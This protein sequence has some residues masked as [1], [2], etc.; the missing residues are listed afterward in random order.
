MYKDDV[1][2]ETLSVVVSDSK[3]TLNVML[4]A[5]KLAMRHYDK[6]SHQG[7]QTLKKFN[8]SQEQKGL[9]EDINEEDV[10]TIRAELKQYHVDF[11]VKE[12]ADGK[13]TLF[14][15]A[16]DMETIQKALKNVVTDLSS[17]LRVAD[18]LANAQQQADQARED[19]SHDRDANRD[20]DLGMDNR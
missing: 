19:P 7:E 8:E 11:A 1:S 12:E 20:R 14:F 18:Q 15:K 4:A 3:L 9:I 10:K 13:Y 5:M 16:K 6:V 17:K 2:S